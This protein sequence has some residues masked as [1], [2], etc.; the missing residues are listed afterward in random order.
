MPPSDFIGGRVGADVTSEA[1][2][3]FSS[4]IVIIIINIIVI[5]LIIIIIIRSK[6]F[7]SS[8]QCILKM[9]LTQNRRRLPPQDLAGS[10]PDQ[11]GAPVVVELWDGDDDD[12]DNG[13]DDDCDD[14]GDDEVPHQFEM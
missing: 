3:V 10:L 4:Y 7:S 12:D 6:S 2:P 8:L 11:A 1:K 5:I 14:N 13:D 9:N